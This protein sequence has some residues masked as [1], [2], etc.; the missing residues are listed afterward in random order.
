MKDRQEEGLVALSTL[1]GK[2]LNSEEV[3][4]ERDNILESILEEREHFVPVI[5]VILC[6]DKTQNLRRM[7]LGCG[8]MAMQQLSG[9]NGLG[10]YMP[11]LLTDIGLTG[12]SSR[13]FTAGYNTMYLISAFCCLLIIDRAGRRPMLFAGSIGMTIAYLLAAFSIL[14]FQQHP[15]HKNSLQKLTISSF[16]IYYFCYGMTYAKLPWCILS[17]IPA[18]SHRTAAAGAATATNWIGSFIVTQFTPPGV[19]NLNIWGFYLLFACFC[20]SFLPISYFFYPETMNRTLEDIDEIFFESKSIFVFRNK[21]LTQR[22]RPQ[23]YI[24]RENQRI[25]NMRAA[26]MEERKLSVEYVDHPVEHKA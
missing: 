3:L 15:E 19:K 22:K 16:F 7:V 4:R 17:E 10:Y 25:E 6:R 2:D 20:I 18:I 1:L 23:A 12:V 9:V 21:N 26:R 13:A 14:G 24:D 8:T 11:T 5:D